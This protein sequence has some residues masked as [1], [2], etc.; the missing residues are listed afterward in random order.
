MVLT[1]EAEGTLPPRDAAAED[2]ERAT[3]A[4]LRDGVR[5][6]EGLATVTC[7]AGRARAVATMAPGDGYLRLVNSLRT[8]TA[9]IGTYTERADPAVVRALY[10]TE[11][12]FLCKDVE[13]PDLPLPWT[14]FSH[15]LGDRYAGRGVAVEHGGADPEFCDMGVEADAPRR[16]PPERGPGGAHAP[17]RRS[18]GSAAL[19]AA[20]GNGDGQHL[21]SP[22]CAVLKSGTVQSRPTSRGR[23]STNSVLSRVVIVS[24][25]NRATRPLKMTDPA[26][27]AG[28]MHGSALPFATPERRPFGAPEGGQIDRP[29]AQ[30]RETGRTDFLPGRPGGTTNFLITHCFY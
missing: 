20:A 12:I 11:A 30:R 8:G 24:G 13:T 25:T 21:P 6:V 4:P 17:D 23:V 5:D 18:A 29:R 9:A 22:A 14:D 2:V 3:A 1:V 15:G 16:H 19:R 7:T 27:E 28:I 10:R 26:G